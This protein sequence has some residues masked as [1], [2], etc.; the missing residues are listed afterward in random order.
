MGVGVFALIGLLY[1][2]AAFTHRWLGLGYAAMGMLLISWLLQTLYLQQWKNLQFY[3]IPTGLYLLS[4]AYLEYQRGHKAQ[5]QWLDY[6]GLALMMGSLFWQT[7][8]FGWG[9]AFLLGVEGALAFWWG[10]ARRLRRFLYAGM[11]AVILATIGQLINAL[12]SINQWI[13]FGAIGLLLVLLAIVIE[14]K[15]DDIKIWQESLE[16]WE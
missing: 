7:M 8:L 12:W 14:R 5:G 2:A 11:V 13:V 16:A 4:I 6:V 15:L 1:L 10:S 3:T 9:Y